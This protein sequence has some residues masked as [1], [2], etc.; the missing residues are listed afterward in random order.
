MVKQS[1]QNVKKG[2]GIALAFLAVNIF[3]PIP[4][5][6]QLQFLN[7]FALGAS[8]YFLLKSGARQ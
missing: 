8:A 4:F 3:Y 7:L 5:L 2:L 6:E 1:I